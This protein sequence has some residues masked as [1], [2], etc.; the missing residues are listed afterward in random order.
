MDDNEIMEN[1][2]TIFDEIFNKLSVNNFKE[3]N[4]LFKFLNS[5]VTLMVDNHH[6][7]VDQFKIGVLDQIDHLLS[8]IN[9]RSDEDDGINRFDEI[10]LIEIDWFSVEFL[11]RVNGGVGDDEVLETAFMKLVTQLLEIGIFNSRSVKPLR[12]KDNIKDLK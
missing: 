3:I 9:N 5:Y 12:D 8:R 6:P 2:P 4:G 7:N 1:L 11:F 10:M